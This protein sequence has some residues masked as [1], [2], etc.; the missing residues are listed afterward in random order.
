MD[1]RAVIVVE[2]DTVFQRIM[3]SQWFKD[4][5]RDKILLMT[6]KGYPDYSSRDFL[7]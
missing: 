3:A 4:N 1:L 5:Y 7:N 6:A 2:K